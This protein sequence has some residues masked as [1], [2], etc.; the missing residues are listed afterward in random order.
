MQSNAKTELNVLVKAPME[1]G[2]IDQ[3][4]NFESGDRYTSSQ[5]PNFPCPLI[6]MPETQRNFK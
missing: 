2:L 3:C 4:A 5:S 1:Y 6:K